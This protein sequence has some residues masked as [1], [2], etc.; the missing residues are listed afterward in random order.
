MLRTTGVSRACSFRI[1]VPHAR[2]PLPAA[3]VFLQPAEKG[4]DECV[5]KFIFESAPY[6]DFGESPGYWHC[7]APE[8]IKV[9]R[10]QDPPPVF[11]ARSFA[12]I[13]AVP[14][15]RFSAVLSERNL[16]CD[17]HS[18]NERPAARTPLADAADADHPVFLICEFH[19]I[20]TLTTLAE[21]AAAER[22]NPPKGI[23]GISQIV[24][25]DVRIQFH[26]LL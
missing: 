26:W 16:L 7:V 20:P 4:F 3:P 10:N 1:M 6:L 14:I 19:K 5:G 13:A 21:F 18:V 9:F 23:R 25:N 2:Q 17:L 8:V 15:L 11:T 22:T 24:I 12:G